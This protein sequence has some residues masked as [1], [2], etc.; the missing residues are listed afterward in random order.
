MARPRVGALL[1]T[2]KGSFV[3]SPTISASLVGNKSV[4]S[5]HLY[6]E[7]WRFLSVLS[8]LLQLD[9]EVAFFVSLTS[10][11]GSKIPETFSTLSSLIWNFENVCW[12]RVES[13]NSI[14]NESEFD[15][16]EFGFFKNCRFG[17]GGD[18]LLPILDLIG[19]EV[20]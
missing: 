15:C 12:G 9:E 13:K 10:F 2:A 14:T 5:V 4:S 17:F 16:K 19:M 8:N 6:P 3:S 18:F 20:F 11:L 1:D 7:T